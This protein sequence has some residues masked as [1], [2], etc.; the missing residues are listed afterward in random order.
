[1]IPVAKGR[2]RLTTINGQARS[3]TPAKTRNAETLMQ[4]S[5]MAQIKN[6]PVIK[7]PT[8]LMVT[9]KFF[10]PRPKHLPKKI[11]LPVTRPDLDN[12]IKTLDALNGYVFEDDSQITTIIAKKR[13]CL[14]DTKPRIIITIQDD[15]E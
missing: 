12:Y 15:E 11:V 13:Y 3:Y 1:M 7:R 2:A 10:L 8:A 14:L 9:A 6:L 5:I 4:Y